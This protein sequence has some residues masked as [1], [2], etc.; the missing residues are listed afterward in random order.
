M[1]CGYPFFVNGK[2]EEYDRIALENII[3]LTQIRD[4]FRDLTFD[5]CIVSCGT[6]MESLNDINITRIFDCPIQDISEYVLNT[7]Q[8]IQ[9]NQNYLYHTPCHDSLKDNAMVL[10][11]KYLKSNSIQKVPYCCSEAGTMALSRPDITNAMLERK[12]HAMRKENT[13]NGLK[14][15][16]NCPSCIQGLGRH[17]DLNLQP[18]HLAQEL[19]FLKEGKNWERKLKTLVRQNEVVT[20]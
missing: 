2:R 16:T 7:D 15:L 11:K 3:I 4:M 1:C 12:K 6:C 14:I 8:T 10:L 13:N 17:Q 9:M 19:A 20:F 18:I 5:A